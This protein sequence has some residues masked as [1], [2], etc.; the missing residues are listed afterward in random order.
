M[1][2]FGVDGPYAHRT[3]PM[4]NSTKISVVLFD[5]AA[6]IESCPRPRRGSRSIASMSRRSGACA[7][8]RWLRSASIRERIHSISDN[9]H[10]QI[11][12]L[13]TDRHLMLVQEM[14]A[15]MREEGRSRYIDSLRNR[16]TRGLGR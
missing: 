8:G 12:T 3:M 9:T 16:C 10:R 1:T 13:L 4:P 6:A 7:T 5:A 2:G 14:Q 11:N 15:R